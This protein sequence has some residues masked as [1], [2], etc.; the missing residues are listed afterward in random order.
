MDLGILGGTKSLQKWRLL[1]L[2]KGLIIRTVATCY[3][4]N[5][6]DCSLHVLACP[7]EISIRVMDLILEFSYQ[8]SET[9]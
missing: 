1:I 7:R 8:N 9:R 3:C 4:L 2:I 6:H 5:G